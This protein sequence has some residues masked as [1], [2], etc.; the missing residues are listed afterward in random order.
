MKVKLQKAIIVLTTGLFWLSVY[1]YMTY[2]TPYL[3][4]MGVSASFAGLVVGAFGAAELLIRMPVGL[5]SDLRS[6]YVPFIVSGC[7][8]QTLAVA[9]RLFSP[10]GTGFLIGAFLSGVG[11]STWTCYM[12]LMGSYFPENEISH[13]I[14]IVS[15]ACNAG[16]VTGYFFGFLFYDQVHMKGILILG[17]CSA[18]AA[19]VCSLFIKE[20]ERRIPRNTSLKGLLSVCKDKRLIFF[21][22]MLLMH[23]GV[24]MATSSSFTMQLASDMGA[25]GSQVGLISII[26][27]TVTI[28]SSYMGATKFASRVGG[29]VWIPLVFV[30][31]AVYCVLMPRTTEVWQIYL[32]QAFYASGQGVL[33]IF[34]TAEAIKNIPSEKKNTAMS[35]SQAVYAGGLVLFPML[36]GAIADS[37]GLGRAFLVMGGVVLLASAVSFAAYRIKKL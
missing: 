3:T 5:L 10:D 30:M 19:T 23:Q 6:R 29:K 31:M 14:G 2:Q 35:F 18:V 24:A 15:M 36:T 21:S 17:L 34:L 8:C 25:N 28:I 9:V 26:G 7:A 32:L 37:L 33:S 27:T 22:L 1:C 12:L 20:P 11:A 4:G 13:A 16:V